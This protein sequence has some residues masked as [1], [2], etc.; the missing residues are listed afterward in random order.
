ATGSPVAEFPAGWP[1]A[2]PLS[3]PVAPAPHPVNGNG[4][5]AAPAPLPVAPNGSA[6]APAFNRPAANGGSPGAVSY[7]PAR[8]VSPAQLPHRQWSRV[9]NPSPDPA[10]VDEASETIRLPTAADG[11]VQLLPGMLVMTKGPDV[12]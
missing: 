4:A 2:E 6:P 12:G 10:R 3:P 1:V 5:S 9:T 7:P 11:T 8:G